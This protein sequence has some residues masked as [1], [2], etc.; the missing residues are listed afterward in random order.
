MPGPSERRS[1]QFALPDLPHDRRATLH[2]GA[3]RERLERHTARS[4]EAARERN[5]ALR[6]LPDS[7]V[8]HY[9]DDVEL[10]A[11]AVQL[12]FVTTPSPDAAASLPV[13][14]LTKVHAPLVARRAAAE[15]RL[16]AGDPRPSARML[17]A[18]VPQAWTDPEMPW[19]VDD[20]TSAVDAAIQCVFQHLEMVSIDPT[21]A[22]TVLDIIEY[23]NGTSDLALAIAE[24][25]AGSVSDPTAGSWV[26]EVPY[27]NADGSP[28]TVMRYLWSDATLAAM[29]GP[30][31]SALQT[32]K[33]TPSLQSSSTVAGCYTVQNGV[34]AVTSTQAASPSPLLGAQF[35]HEV[36][37]DD[38][39]GVSWT[40]NDLTPQNGF[41]YG[42]D[43][44]FDDNVFSASF[45]NSWLRWLSGYVEFLGPGGEA[46]ALAA[47]SWTSQVPAGAPASYDSPTQKYVAMFSAVDTILSIPIGGQPTTVSF[48]WPSEASAVR[49]LAGGLGRTGGIEGQDGQY[50]GG[51]DSQVCAA[52]TLMTGV[53]NFGIPVICLVAGAAIPET[54]LSD[55]AKSFAAEILDV[56]SALVDGPLAGA[57]SSESTTGILAAIADA[58]PHILLDLPDLAAA[59]DAA[60]A[61]EDAT[62]EATPVFGWI[63]LGLS[64]VTTIS[65]LLQ[66]SAEVAQSPAT[67]EV[68]FTRAIDASWELLPDVDHQNTWPLDATS[69]SVTATFTDGTTRITTGA[70]TPPQYGPITVSFDAANANPLPG[71]GTVVFTATFLAAT[72]WVCGAATSPALSAAVDGP[73]VVPTQAIVENEVPLTAS[74]RYEYLQSLTWDAQSAQHAWSTDPADMPTA[75]VQSL[76]PS[77][78]GATLGALGQI[79][80]NE[81]QSQL[82]YDYQASGQDLPVTGGPPTPT[83]DQLY[84]LQTVSVQQDAEDGLRFVASGFVDGVPVAYGLQA[85]ATGTNFYIDPTDQLYSVRQIVLDGSSGTLS[86]PQDVSWGRFNEAIDASTVHPSGYVVGVNTVNRKLEVLALPSSPTT[87]AAAPLAEIYC[88]YG[89][90]PGLLHQPVGVA[91]AVGSGVIVLEATDTTLPGGDARLQAFDLLGNP[92]PIFAGGSCTALLT[93]ESTPVTA[94]AVATESQGYMYVLKYLGDGSAADDYLLDIYAPDGAFVS[95]TPGLAAGS[96]AV[97]LWRTVYTLDY[98]QIVKPAGLRPEPSVSWWT[99]S[100]PQ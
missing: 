62:E 64:V 21:T 40:I 7:L 51:W 85:P 50:Y 79:T 70:M 23:A 59:I 91:P 47:G 18:G 10:P 63:A 83:D 9:V 28:S 96:I 54:A 81:A 5:R 11:T 95:Q 57:A 39:S 74:T 15:R 58:M 97:D 8:T 13:M 99:P 69:Y 44:T 60:I 31:M 90:R 66:T 42:N 93:P 46:I 6:L 43:L 22:A 19:L 78:T 67:F 84:V 16:E 75:T 68:V 24:Q 30:V 89:T 34:T 94:L 82:G 41:S 20:W 26:D 25:V 80:V 29:P 32:V 65:D 100:A 17:F 35:R 37:Q 72:G 3:R 87:D 77:D 14:L 36:A 88:G 1:L 61:V 49:L 76:D 55:L 4:R 98:A 38:G 86:L 71:G 52:G 92:A 53:F 33:N 12:L 73:L 45:T 48:P 56:G 2:V 27:V